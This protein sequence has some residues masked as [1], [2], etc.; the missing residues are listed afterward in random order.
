MG[1][2]HTYNTGLDIWLDN[3]AYHKCQTGAVM[4]EREKELR[5][6]A[7][8]K[9]NN[10][11]LYSHQVVSTFRNTLTMVKNNDFTEPRSKNKRNAILNSSGTK[12]CEIRKTLIWWQLWKSNL[13][14]EMK[15]EGRRGV[16]WGIKW[17]MT[18]KLFITRLYLPL[19]CFCSL[20]N[21]WNPSSASAPLLKECIG[22]SWKSA[23]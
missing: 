23:H 8:V 4:S 1:F 11:W 16:K 18:Q 21:Q 6:L 13:S 9:K 5:F 2:S 22:T 7:G 17:K 12:E 15:Q 3:K 19:C 20:Y 10:T 14:V